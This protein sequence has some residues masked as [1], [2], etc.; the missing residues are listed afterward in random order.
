MSSK[1]DKSEKKAD[2]N[3]VK[4]Q[5]YSTE[6]VTGNGTFGVVF[7]AYEKGTNRKVAIKKVLQ[8]PRYKNRELQI[9]Q[10][11]SHPNVVEML[12]CFFSRGGSKSQRDSRDVYLNLVMEYVPETIYQTIRTHVRALQT[13]PFIYAKLYT[14][15]ICRAINY[16]HNMGICHRDIKPQNLLLDP[17]SHTVKLCDFGS[18]KILVKGQPNVAYICSRYYRAPELIFESTNYTTS[19]DT[20]SLGCVVS[21]MFLGEP[22]FQGGSSLDQLVEIIKVLGAPS[23]EAILSMNH[24][25]TSFRFP[26]VKPLKWEAVFSGVKHDGKPMSESAIDFIKSMLVFNPSQRLLPFTALAHPFFDE[27]RDPE[28]TLPNGKKITNIFTLTDEEIDQAEQ[29]NILDK[30]APAAMVAE[31]RSSSAAP[32]KASASVS[33]DQA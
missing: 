4:S 17:E 15:Q 32:A 21:E 9:M 6:R 29:L 31:L 19:I 16:C 23:K 8:D 25:Y 26:Q 28:T 27:L 5:K 20:W 18:A 1:I 13:I 2:A 14:Y 7:E 10:M 22:L 24:N 3:S 11:V 12:D 33:D 30:V